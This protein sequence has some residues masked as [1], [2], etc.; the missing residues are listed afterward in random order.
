MTLPTV[1]SLSLVNKKRRRMMR[2]AAVL[3]LLLPW[4]ASAEVVI[5]ADGSQ[6]S[7]QSYQRKGELL[8]MTTLDGKLRSVPCKYIDLEATEQRNRSGKATAPKSR[9]EAPAPASTP[10][11]YPRSGTAATPSEPSSDSPENPR[12][13]GKPSL[14]APSAAP[15]PFS[16][17]SAYTA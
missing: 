12:Q 15:N 8:V 14:P 10:L 13:L 3:I 17:K 16:A 7:V 1:S 2:R 6:L 9:D 4:D 5:L 11:P